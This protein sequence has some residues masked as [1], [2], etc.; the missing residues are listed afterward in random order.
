M[1]NFFRRFNLWLERN[2][3]GKRVLLALPVVVLLSALLSYCNQVKVPGNISKNSNSFATFDQAPFANNELLKGI[4]YNSFANEET[5]AKAI[6]TSDIENAMTNACNEVFASNNIALATTG[7]E[8]INKFLTCLRYAGVYS[9]KSYTDIQATSAFAY[10]KEVTVN[11]FSSQGEN[12]RARIIS[13][14]KLDKFSLQNL[15]DASFYHTI[16]ST[17]F[18]EALTLCK[19]YLEYAGVSDFFAENNKDLSRSIAAYEACALLALYYGSLSD[20]SYK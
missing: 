9:G 12:L 5:T 7:I 16:S 8:N 14:Y 3:W 1:N 6:P 15:R 2:P 20:N 19:L 11:R 10:P 13:N 17:Q 18:T 4:T